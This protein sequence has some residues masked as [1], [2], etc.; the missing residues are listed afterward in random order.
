MFRADHDKQT[1]ELATA[2]TDQVRDATSVHSIKIGVIESDRLLSEGLAALL[3]TVEEFECVGVWNQIKEALT[4]MQELRLDVLLLDIR[5][6]QGAGAAHFQRLPAISPTTRVL[7]T[8]NCPKEG[9]AAFDGPP[10]PSQFAALALLPALQFGMCD[11]VNK[12]CGFRWIAR[13]IH[14]AYAEARRIDA[15]TITHFAEP[16]L[17]SLQS[18]PTIEKTSAE[19]LTLRERQVIRLIGQGY[20]NKAIAQEMQLGYS[21]V[22]NYVSSVLKKL[23]LDGRTQIALYARIER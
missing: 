9:G 19:N 16:Y 10:L 12:E 21:T 23:Q 2:D 20:S 15:A 4:A 5:L 11:I 14:K 18:D 8:M 17:R 13:Y 3:N 1:S 7:L 22:K 6:L